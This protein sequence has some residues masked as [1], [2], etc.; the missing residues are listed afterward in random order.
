MVPLH[1]RNWSSGAFTF[2]PELTDLPATVPHFHLQHIGLK[3]PKVKLLCE[4]CG[5][6]KCV[7]R[8]VCIEVCVCE[9]CVYV[10]CVCIEVCVYVRCV[11]M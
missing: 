1:R 9:V 4:V 6:V 7:V 2:P 11:C 10:R 3:S 8:C 5:Y